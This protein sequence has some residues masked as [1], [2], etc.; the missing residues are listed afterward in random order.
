MLLVQ[1][2]N[3]R[4][5]AGSAHLVAAEGLAQPAVVVELAVED[6]G[7]A[8]A[9]VRDR[10]APGLQV[11]HAQAL[12]AEDAGAEADARALVRPAVPDRRAHR[13]DRTRIG[14]AV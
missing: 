4:R 1:V 7:D 2:R 10:L 11:E 9:L 12:V 3:H 14:R 5:V 13:V 8:A 6:G